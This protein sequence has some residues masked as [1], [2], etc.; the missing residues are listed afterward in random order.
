M[1]NDRYNSNNKYNKGIMPE[2]IKIESLE[3][4][5]LSL[6]NNSKNIYTKNIKI[7]LVK[8]M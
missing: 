7:Y 1:N 2:K 6:S 3:K 4:Q 5:K 8:K